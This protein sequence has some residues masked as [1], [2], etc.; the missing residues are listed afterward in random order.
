MK[1]WLFFFLWKAE[2]GELKLCVPY[3]NLYP[4]A[5]AWLII[6][7]DHRLTETENQ[8]A[9]V[10]RTKRFTRALHVPNLYCCESQFFFFI[11]FWKDIKTLFLCALKVCILLATFLPVPGNHFSTVSMSLSYYLESIYKWCH[12]LFGSLYLAYFV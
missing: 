12:A 10:G 11:S 9:S 2:Q 1:V 5:I 7:N 8:E 4:L 6:Y 3:A